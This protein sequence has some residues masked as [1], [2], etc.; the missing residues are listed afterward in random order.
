M[1]DD[2]ISGRVKWFDAGRGYGFIQR[3]GDSDVYVNIKEVRQAGLEDLDDG[4]PVTFTIRRTSRGPRAQ[5]IALGKGGEAPAGSELQSTRTDFTFDAD[6]LAGGYF[7]DEEKKYLRPDVLDTVAIDVAKVLGT[8]RPPMPMH[9]MRRFFNKARGIEA[10][11]DREGDFRAVQAD[12]VG[13]RRD[14]AYQV[15]RE[16]VP[17][18]FQSFITRN[19]T[20]ALEDE[21]SFRKGFLPHF[22]SVLAY[23]VYFFQE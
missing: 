10:K 16:L 17:Q 6:Y 2:R 9:Q 13:F 15:G 20:L 21:R 5:E 1:S 12:I 11:L 3:Q 18:E 7:Q 19:V 8:A 14:V 23:F 22:E 4:Q